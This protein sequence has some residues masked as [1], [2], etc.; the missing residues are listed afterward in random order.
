MAGSRPRARKSLRGIAVVAAPVATL[1]LVVGV[2]AAIMWDADHP[3]SARTGAV[4]PQP[5]VSAS[6]TAA[7][8]AAH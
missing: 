7:H 5:T 3:A 1:A 4:E 2:L 8:P 6:D